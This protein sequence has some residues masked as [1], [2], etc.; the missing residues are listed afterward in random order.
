MKFIKYNSQVLKLFSPFSIINLSHFENI[1]E[2]CTLIYFTKKRNNRICFEFDKSRFQ[3]ENNCIAN[4]GEYHCFTSVN[5]LCLCCDST[6]PTFHWTRSKFVL[7][8]SIRD[9]NC[10]ILDFIHFPLFFWLFGNVGELSSENT[11]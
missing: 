8:A 1:F 3:L 11:T 5:F 9:Y 10:R 4:L 6:G 7:V 2:I